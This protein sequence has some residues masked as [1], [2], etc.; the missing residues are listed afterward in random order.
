MAVCHLEQYWIEANRDRWR[1]DPAL[2]GGGQLYDSGSHLL[3]A[4]LWC[5]RATPE[6]V[7][8]TVDRRGES[9]DVNA[10][11]SATLD[12]DGD[13]VTAS[14]GVSG[15]G[16]TAP[17]TGESLRVLGTD[18]AVAFDGE[19]VEVTEAGTTYAATPRDPGFEALT[20]AKLRNFVA[21]VRGEEPLEIPVADAVRVTALTE[22]A[23]E[24]AA[25]G[26]RVA[27]DLPNLDGPVDGPVDRERPGGTSDP[28]PARDGDATAGSDGDGD[29][30]A[31]SDGDGDATAGSD[32]DG[33]EECGSDDEGGT[34]AAG[35]GGAD[36]GDGDDG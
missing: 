25:T 28:V 8:A 9:V 29:A 4:L 6:S 3:D 11:L 31:G 20:R 24:A 21:A 13:R 14:V 33:D 19:T 16:V 22:A 5:L 17:D 1:G 27:V 34:A 30:T 12:R 18:G 7:A 15:A 23:Y 36:A 26:R 10:A 35:D 32:G 2:S